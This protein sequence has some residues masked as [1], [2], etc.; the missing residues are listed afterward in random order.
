MPRLNNRAF[1]VLNQELQRLCANKPLETVRYSI[2]LKRLEKLRQQA[3]APLTYSEIKAEIADIFPEFSDRILK[4]AARLNQ[5]NPLVRPAQWIASLAIGAGAIAGGLWLVNLPYPMIRWPVARTAPLL[6]LPSFMRMDHN[7]RQ[8]IIYTEQADQL[9]NNATSA[10]D[11]ELGEAKADQAQQHLNQLPVWFLGYYPQR[12]CAWFNCGWRFT[13]DEFEAARA[14]VGRMEAQIFQEQNALQ[15]LAAGTE[16]VA[17]AKQ[18]YETVQSSEEKIAILAEWQKGMD[19]LSEIPPGTLAGQTAQTRLNAF[20]RDYQTVA[21]TS[22]DARQ[23]NSY[24]Q[25]AKQ[26]AVQASELVQNPP[27]AASRWQE[28]ARLWEDAI[29]QLNQVQDASPG[30]AEAQALRAKYQ[31]NLS[32]I[33]IRQT[34]EAAA[35]QAFGQIQERVT[36][37]IATTQQP[38]PETLAELEQI[39][40]RLD[41]VPAGTT[42]SQ[43]AQTLRSQAAAHL[44]K[45]QNAM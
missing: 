15:Q 4:Q 9:I 3:G 2:V 39:I 45:L 17:A 44:Q 11:F 12:Y 13:L 30:Y 22:A 8:A 40:N 35:V 16:A 1:A 26:Y 38:S 34:E 19:Q 41:D 31:R 14:L 37:L 36:R 10:Q 25:A 29:Q 20:Q 27:H 42:V 43:S 23:S 21:G 33:R 32:E 6:L 24:V 18:R 28:A 5:P 7:Y